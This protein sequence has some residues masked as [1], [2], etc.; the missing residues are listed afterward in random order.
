MHKVYFFKFIFLL[1]KEPFLENEVKEVNVA[2]N[3][4]E[5]NFHNENS[6]DEL[7]EVYRM[8]KL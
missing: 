2:P 1:A 4:E 7:I 5:M 6:N 8:H 3:N